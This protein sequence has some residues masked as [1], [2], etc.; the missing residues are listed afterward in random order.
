[1]NVKYYLNGDVYNYTQVQGV[2]PILKSGRW[3]YFITMKV[4]EN[5]R[6]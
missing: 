4:S 5:G 2:F 6:K 1:M 3:H